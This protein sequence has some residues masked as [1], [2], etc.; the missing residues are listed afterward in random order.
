MTAVISVYEYVQCIEMCFNSEH[1]TKLGE[2]HCTDVQIRT[3][4]RAAGNHVA[5]FHAII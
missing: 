2:K 3:F 4:S 1:H 5:K